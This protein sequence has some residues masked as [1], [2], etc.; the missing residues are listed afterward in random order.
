MA[1]RVVLHLLFEGFKPW[2]ERNE[3]QMWPKMRSKK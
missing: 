3:W 1:M 2:V